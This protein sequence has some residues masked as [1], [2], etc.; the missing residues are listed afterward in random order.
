M[1]D[2]SWRDHAT[3]IEVAVIYLTKTPI[4]E[5]EETVEA[6]SRLKHITDRITSFVKSVKSEIPDGARWSGGGYRTKHTSQGYDYSFN[7]EAILRDLATHLAEEAGIGVSVGD[8]YR[9][10]ARQGAVKVEWSISGLEK[11]FHALDLPLT[12]EAHQVAADIE[13]PA[14]VGKVKKPSKLE[15]VPEESK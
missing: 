13:S 3:T 10:A 14:H 2:K 5:G 7:E 4:P 1:S 12:I 6:L 8:A 9:Y 15:I 11:M